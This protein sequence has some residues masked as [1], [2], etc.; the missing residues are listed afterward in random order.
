MKN[1]LTE[2]EIFAIRFSD[3]VG[4]LAFVINSVIEGPVKYTRLSGK[5][6]IEPFIL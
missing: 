1:M 2:K 6:H 5:G 4:I 3:S